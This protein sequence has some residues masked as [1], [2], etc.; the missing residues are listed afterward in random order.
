MR[1]GQETRIYATNNINVQL[2]N[3]QKANNCVIFV[4]M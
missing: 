1:I 4:T 2:A 3:V